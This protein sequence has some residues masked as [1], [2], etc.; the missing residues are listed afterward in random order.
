MILDEEGGQIGSLAIVDYKTAT[1]DRADDL[2]AFQLAVYAAAGRGEGLNV[3]AAYLHQLRDSVRRPI[4]VSPP[5]VSD[6]VM[7]VNR[8]VQGLKEADYPAKP[9]I[10]KCRRCTLRCLCR[11]ALCDP[12]DLE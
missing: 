3:D 1:D 2:F 5:V 9:E 4:D 6:A 11:H 10:V 7:R 8:I 12:L